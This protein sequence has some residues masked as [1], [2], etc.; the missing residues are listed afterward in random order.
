[1]AAVRFLFGMGEAGAFPIATRSLSRW[2]LPS[3]R[4]FSQGITHAGSRLGAALTP[5][6]VAYL[7]AGYGWRTPFVCFGMLGL[8]CGIGH[9]VGSCLGQWVVSATVTYERGCVFPADGQP[10][11]QLAG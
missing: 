10:Q 11:Y 2:M 1:M 8:V 9:G 5:A 6:L 7:I 3:E 4:G